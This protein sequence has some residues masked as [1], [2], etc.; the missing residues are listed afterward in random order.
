MDEDFANSLRNATSPEEFMAIIDK[1]DDEKPVSMSVWLRLLFPKIL[2][3]TPRRLH[4]NCWLLQAARPVSH[5][6]IWQQKGLKNRK[7][8][9]MCR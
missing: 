3:T 4:L 5:I 2:P 6:L 9:G 8:S 1:A 7:R